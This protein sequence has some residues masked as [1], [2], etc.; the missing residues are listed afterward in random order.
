MTTDLS[1]FHETF[2]E[3]SFEALDG[4]ESSLLS[5]DVGAPDPEAINTIFR[6]PHSIKGGAAERVVALEDVAAELVAFA[7]D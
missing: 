3:E 7:T 1:E 6:G 2:F 4:M 5:L